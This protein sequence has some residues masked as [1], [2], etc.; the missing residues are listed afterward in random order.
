V[1]RVKK[2][3]LQ[4]EK[5]CFI[6]GSTENLH[7]HH[8]YFGAGLRKISDKHGFG[9]YLR[10]DWHNMADYGVHFNSALDLNLKRMCQKKFEETHTREEFMNL[11]HR[12]YL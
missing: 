5:V 6:T 7:Y 10:A 8:I 2:S 1:E 12:N 11:I 4:T 9:V 3:I